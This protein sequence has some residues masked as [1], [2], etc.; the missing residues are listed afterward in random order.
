MA[1]FYAVIKTRFDADNTLVS[2]PFVGLY[3]GE[4]PDSEDYPFCVLVPAE[5]TKQSGSFASNYFEEN[6]EFHV[7]DRTQ[8][9]VEA[10]GDLVE[11]AFRDCETALSVTG[12]TVVRLALTA[13]RSMQVEE[14]LWEEVLEY[15]AD[16]CKER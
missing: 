3:M 12:L 11:A 13:R 8:E 10:H 6:F 5:E 9:L 7:A 2:S 15:T 1:T 14:N 16:Y 4:A